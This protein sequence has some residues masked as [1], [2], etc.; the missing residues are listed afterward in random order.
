MPKLKRPSLKMKKFA[1]EYVKNGGN[2]TKAVIATYE[3]KDKR[4]AGIMAPTLLDN[5]M[6]QEEIKKILNN[7][8]LDLETIADSTKT[9]LQSSLAAKP[10]FAAGVTLLQF[11]YKL[12]GVTP[13]NKSVAVKWSATQN[14]ASKDYDSLR[15]ELS[16]L[17]D[18][19]NSLLT[20]SNK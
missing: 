15:Q 12:H 14:V 5:P 7:S 6:V 2:G 9:A 18:S 11:L 4:N 13:A 1:R 16:K 20:L 3:V 19:V 8:G 17:N 10:S